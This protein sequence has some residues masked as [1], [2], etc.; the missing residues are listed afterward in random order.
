MDGAKRAGFNAAAE[1]GEY[2]DA[3]PIARKAEQRQAHCT[4]GEGWQGVQGTVEAGEEGEEEKAGRLYEIAMDELK[5]SPILQKMK[6]EE[7]ARR[8]ARG[9]NAE[10]GAS[11]ALAQRDAFIEWHKDK[12]C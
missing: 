9:S 3:S 10:H 7:A 11:P 8:A 12:Q 2:F 5:T 6:A 1:D 4:E